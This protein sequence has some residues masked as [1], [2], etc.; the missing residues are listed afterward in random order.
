MVGQ[1]RNKYDGE[2]Y[3]IIWNMEYYA[4]LVFYAGI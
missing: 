1:I 2:I 3:Y 4:I